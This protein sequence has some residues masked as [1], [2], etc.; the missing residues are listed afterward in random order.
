MPAARVQW[1]ARP[2]MAWSWFF[3]KCIDGY[4]CVIWIDTERSCLVQRFVTHSHCNGHSNMLPKFVSSS[5]GIEYR[6]IKPGPTQTLKHSL[7]CRNQIDKDAVISH[8]PT[9]PLPMDLLISTS[10]LASE[11]PSA[12]ARRTCCQETAPFPPSLHLSLSL[13][14]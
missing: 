11:E 5:S 14:L 12:A 3:M 10:L 2:G 1:Q 4:D 13:S 7:P 6:V 9:P 8:S